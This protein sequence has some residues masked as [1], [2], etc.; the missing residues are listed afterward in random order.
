MK[1]WNL[2]YLWNQ[3]ESNSPHSPCKGE[4]PSLGTCQP[5]YFCYPRRIRT[6]IKWT[7]T[8]CPAI[9]R[10]GNLWLVIQDLNL[11]PLRYQRSA[12]TNWANHQSIVGRGGLE[13]P[14]LDFQSSALTIFATVPFL[15]TNM[16]KNLKTKNPNLVSSG[17]LFRL[18]CFNLKH[19]NL[20]IR[21]YTN[22]DRIE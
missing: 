5:I 12:L 22:S 15:T 13:P 8:T 11:W 4:S 9:R 2:C 1:I 17:I 20:Q 7:K 19:P 16:S 10:E 3:W 21:E 6:S 18:L 14:W